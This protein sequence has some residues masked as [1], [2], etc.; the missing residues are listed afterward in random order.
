M[1]NLLNI[2]LYKDNDLYIDKDIN[3]NIENKCYKYILDDIDNTIYIDGDSL[4]LTRE[5]DE[6][7]MILTIDNNGKH[8]CTYLLKEIDT[9]FDILVDSATFSIKDKIMDIY[10]QLESA[11]YTIHILI[12]LERN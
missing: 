6:Y 5:N 8:S 1:D 10:Y 9:T 7:K 11:D 4:I 2:K 12:S 3:Y